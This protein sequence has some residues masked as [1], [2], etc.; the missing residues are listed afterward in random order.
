MMIQNSST[1]HTY[2]ELINVSKDDSN[3]CVQYSLLGKLIVG[4]EKGCFFQDLEKAGHIQECVDFL[5]EK[6]VP[7]VCFNPVDP[8]VFFA[9][10]G[11]SIYSFDS[12]T[13]ME[14]FVMKF[15]DNEDEVN[16]IQI[17]D[18]HLVACDDAGECKLYDISTNKCFRTL[19]RKHANICSS[20]LFPSPNKDILITGGLDSQIISW[21]Y[22]RVKVLS[23]ANMQTVLK[24]LGDDSV[25]MFN[26]PLVHSLGLSE[27]FLVAGLG[28]GSLQL[29]NMSATK[30]HLIPF[31]VVNK[32]STLGVS[33][34]SALKGSNNDIILSGGNDGMVYAWGFSTITVGNTR[35]KLV[36]NRLSTDAET[37][38]Y[39]IQSVNFNS[40]INCV[41]TAF[42]QNENIVFV[43]DQTSSLKSFR[44]NT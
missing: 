26:P 29:F 43:C 36:T 5:V 3:L 34:I 16:A 28:N 23:S 2:P 35:K 27:R 17:K 6:E 12:R 13:S 22:S 24:Q 40:K 21:D 25:F 8:S 30:Q 1:Y 38:N 9:C 37:E 7:S 10:N 14:K 18:K 39:L 33:T 42:I 11:N 31:I 19:R 20:L 44:I 41:S 32:H 15:T 4:N